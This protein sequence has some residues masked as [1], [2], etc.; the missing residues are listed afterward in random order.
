MRTTFVGLAVLVAASAVGSASGCATPSLVISL[1][2]RNPTETIWVAG[3]E[4]L[5]KE[6]DGAERGGLVFLPIDLDASY[7]WIHVRAGG[8]TFAFGFRQETTFVD[9]QKPNPNRYRS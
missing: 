4:S 6:Q 1:V 5:V 3:R 8:K 7:V 9:D 2:P